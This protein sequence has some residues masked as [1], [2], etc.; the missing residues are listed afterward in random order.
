MKFNAPLH[1]KATV[2]LAT[3]ALLSTLSGCGQADAVNTTNEKTQKQAQ[4]EVSIPVEVSTL[5]QGTI[6]ST[7]SSTT[8][9]ESKEEAQV[10]SKV[11]GIIERILVEEGDYVEQG[12]L[13][14]IIEPQRYQLALNK[15]KAELASIEEELKRIDKV[16]S[17]NLI[18]TDARDKLKWQRESTA[19]SLAIAE[20]D[21]AETQ[22]LA[23]ISGYIAERYVKT[24]N[25]VQRHTSKNMF[26]I[27]QQ[28]ALQGVVH[29][30]E[31]E[32]AQITQGQHAELRIA[33]LGSQG[34]R[35]QVERIS[36]VV[37]ADTGTFRVTLNVPNPNNRLKPGMFA[38]VELSYDTHNNALLLPRKALISIDNQHVV[39]Q[40]N[41]D[42]KA[43]RQN[44]EI[45]Y[46]QGEYVEVLQGLNT[47]SQVVIAGHHNLKDQALVD[48]IEQL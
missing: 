22:V 48:I 27:V 17:K 12:Q 37:D 20:L 47:D 1:S 24:G 46:Q 21:L 26:H 31:K 9:L 45:G 40:V 18:S 32:L 29:L 15:A 10:V 2:L 43:L 33:S 13:L 11:S 41:E 39:Y 36:P 23:P 6:S 42:N 14:A 4:P 25:L 7:Y 34:V 30:P 8:V 3:S 28:K 16:H 44:V 38:D 35:A 5:Q 19:A